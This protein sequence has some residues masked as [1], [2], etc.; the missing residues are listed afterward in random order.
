MSQTCWRGNTPLAFTDDAFAHAYQVGYLQF[1]V[2]YETKTPSVMDIYAL[3]VGVITNVHHSG[4]YLAGYVTGWIA[5]LVEAYKP[6]VL[7]PSVP[8]AKPEEVKL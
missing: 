2:D 8:Q 5:A 4:R 1:K 6:S 3:V 7:A